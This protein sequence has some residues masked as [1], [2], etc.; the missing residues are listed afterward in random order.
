MPV[1]SNSTSFEE[2][3]TKVVLP[4]SPPPLLSL[5]HMQAHMRYLI[6]ILN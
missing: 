4:L 5:L 1:D 3:I 6:I 2:R